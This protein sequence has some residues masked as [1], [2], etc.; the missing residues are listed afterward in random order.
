MARVPNSLKPEK[1]IPIETLVD[2]VRVTGLITHL[3]P[4]DMSIEITSPASGWGT[5]LHV[6]HFAMY[7]CNWLATHDGRRTVALTERG[8]SR[9]DCM[10]RQLYLGSQGLPTTWNVYRVPVAAHGSDL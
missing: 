9:A 7:E 3:Y 8:R 5:G 4:N 6:P 2:G 1:N 10:L